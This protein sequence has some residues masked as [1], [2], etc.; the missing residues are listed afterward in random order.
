[1]GQ[2]VFFYD[3]ADAYPGPQHWRGIARVV[4]HEGSRT[5]W[6][7]HRGMLIAASPEHLSHANQ[8]ELNGWLVTSNES[9][10]MDAQP[11]AGGAGFLDIR[12]KAT[13]PAEGFPEEDPGKELEAEEMEELEKDAEPVE[14][15]AQPDN[16]D[17][18][19][20]Q[21]DDQ[22]Q[23]SDLSASSTSMA[24]MELESRREMK[25]SQRSFDFFEAQKKRR[26]AKSGQ[27]RVA[28]KIRE[29]LH[30]PAGPEYD[31]DIDSY[32]TPEASGPSPL[33]Q[34]D[35]DGIE[36]QERASKRLRAGASGSEVASFGFCRYAIEEEDFLT[37]Q[38][39]SEF[40]C[41]AEYFQEMGLD[42]EEFLF[43]VERNDF[44]MRY[45]QMAEEMSFKVQ[46]AEVP[47]LALKKKGR[48]EVQLGE[49][50]EHFK[51]QFTEPGGSGEREWQAWIE[52]DAC[53]VLSI[54]ESERIAAR[55]PD[56]IIPTRWVRTNKADGVPDAPFKAK[57]RLVVQGFRDRALGQFRR[58]APTASSLAESICLLITATYGFVL[59]SKDVKNA[60]F[61]GKPIQRDLYLRQ[62]RGGLPRL[63]PKQLL[64]AKKAIYGFAEAARLFWLALREQLMSDGW[65][66]SRLEPALFYLRERGQLRGI[67]VTH[68]DD[69]EA[70]VHPEWQEKAFYKTAKAL[71]FS[72]N[73]IGSFTFRG[74]ELRQ[75]PEGHI[76][77]TMSNY[78]RSMRPVRISRERRACLEARLNQEEKEL[79]QSSSGELGWITRQLR[80]DLAYENGCVQRCKTD[81]CVADLVRL[82]QAVAAAR[83]AADFRQRYWADTNLETAVVVH[84]ADS[85]HANGTPEND[86]I[87]KYRSVGGYYILLADAGILSGEEVRANI[88]TYHS[89]QTKRVCRST[90]A[91]EA[92]HLAE[93]VEAGD[94]VIVLLQEAIKGEIDLKHWDSIVE[95]RPRVYVTDAQS[96]YD[97]LAKDSTA[98]SSDK[99]MAI[100]GALL[101]ETVRRP[102]AYTRW[103][104]G[105]QNI[106]NVLTKARA[107]QT[108]LFDFMR[109]G[110]M[111]LAQTEKNRQ[112]KEKKRLQ[113]QNRKQVVK[114][115][116]FKE[117][118]REERITKLA[119]EMQE[120]AEESSDEQ[121][122]TKEK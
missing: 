90:L 63:H 89:T 68:V 80:S 30:V 114:A 24:R 66:E 115:S 105:E 78:A 65:S 48:K 22:L 82:R 41:K 107:D 86:G 73:E 15:A 77:V 3:Q 32:R 103:I 11:G 27:K 120:A 17:P 88:L 21:P 55:H 31:P 75:S 2:F 29:G 47:N 51:K 58:D 62:P 98:M 95:S 23:P 72:T 13:P 60:Y 121:K 122:S 33:P 57:S 10:L 104:D 52:K 34:I 87:M 109:T 116:G 7:S 119:K 40:A 118:Q 79:L 81:P 71:E 53:E 37:N 83:R 44:H 46:S 4:G 69:I 64:K 101:R 92:A 28:E 50:E 42:E 74:R 99:R 45:L 6:L 91:A 19:V 43:G 56:Q 59:L 76:D 70:G 67:L 94:W 25:R 18:S 20:A 85:G 96:V 5:V 16:V 113:R 93:A 108:V 49:L 106:A 14:T 117:K 54:E 8:D 111:S 9:I 36:A 97:Y 61:S 35:E 1:M 102:L 39:K 112:S 12:G 110:K 100:E 26:E 84:L 38:A